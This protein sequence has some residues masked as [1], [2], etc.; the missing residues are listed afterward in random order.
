[1]RSGI[2]NRLE[3]QYGLVSEW[4]S[5]PRTTWTDPRALHAKAALEEP[6]E[7]VD[8]G[9]V[10]VD[11]D[12]VRFVAALL[13]FPVE[14]GG[15][16]ADDEVAGPGL[17]DAVGAGASIVRV[18]GRIVAEAG[19]EG[20]IVGIAAEEVRE[21]VEGGL[22]ILARGM[23]TV[24]PL[25]NESASDSERHRLP[26]DGAVRAPIVAAAERPA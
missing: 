14:G 3:I 23:Q 8:E 24:V 21:R 11:G 5:D 4:S 22:D 7:S 12:L 1:M 18:L 20:A 2:V 16:A 13:V 25:S 19:D 17:V 6:G 15:S 26:R 9:G 10:P